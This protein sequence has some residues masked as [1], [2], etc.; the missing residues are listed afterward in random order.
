MSRA[1]TKFVH[2]STEKNVGYVIHYWSIILACVRR[3]HFGSVT[4]TFYSLKFSQK[5]LF[6]VVI[7]LFKNKWKKFEID[8]DSKLFF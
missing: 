6:W 5:K 3:R 8:Y 7:Y 4:I 2:E 1:H